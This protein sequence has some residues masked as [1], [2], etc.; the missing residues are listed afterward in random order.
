MSDR[1]FEFMVEDAVGNLAIALTRRERLAEKD[2]L[3]AVYHSD[4]YRRLQNPK[5]GLYFESSASL[6]HLFMKERKAEKA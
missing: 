5:S 4:F 2:A 3:K 1:H 6:V